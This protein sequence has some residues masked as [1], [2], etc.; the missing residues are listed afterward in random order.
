MQDHKVRLRYFPGALSWDILHYVN[1]KLEDSVFDVAIIHISAKDLLN[2]QGHINQINYILQNI[3]HIV[4]KCRQFD[5]QNIFLFWLTI[6]NRLPKQLIKE[7]NISICNICSGRP[8]LDFI[9]N[10]NITLNEFCR[11]S[12]HLPLV[13]YALI[14]NYLDNICKNVLEVVQHPRMKCTVELFGK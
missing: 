13:K 11:D 8:N 10:V 14:N 2:S 7:F 6:T 3:E 9:D 4:Y 12:L 1:L 5:L